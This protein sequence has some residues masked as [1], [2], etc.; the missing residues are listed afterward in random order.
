MHK[1]VEALILVI[2]AYIGITLTVGYKKE[3]NV[4]VHT[5]H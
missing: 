4:T 5:N 2:I 1:F 3:N